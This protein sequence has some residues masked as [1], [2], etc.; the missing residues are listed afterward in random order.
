M[1]IELY[2]AQNKFLGSVDSSSH[3]MNYSLQNYFSKLQK[4]TDKWVW[5]NVE[6]DFYLMDESVRSQTRYA[7]F[8]QIGKGAENSIGQRGAKYEAHFY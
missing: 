8:I 2:D 4:S 7:K 3:I 5:H 1:I 6:I